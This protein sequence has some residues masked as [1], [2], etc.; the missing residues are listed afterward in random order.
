[1]QSTGCGCCRSPPSCARRVMLALVISPCNGLLMAVLRV[2]TTCLSPADS[3]P[4]KAR[5]IPRSPPSDSDSGRAHGRC[6]AAG[7]GT[8]AR[9]WRQVLHSAT[10]ARTSRPLL[11]RARCFVAWR[12]IWWL[13]GT[14]VLHVRTRAGGRPARS[15]VLGF[16]SPSV[17]PRHP[18]ARRC[19]RCGDPPRKAQQA[20]QAQQV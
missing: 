6:V 8:V 1:M 10:I 14:A 12:S 2:T 13:C 20:Q 5:E 3:R 18:L 9:R 17:S 16:P 11:V 19:G 15:A 4:G 7:G